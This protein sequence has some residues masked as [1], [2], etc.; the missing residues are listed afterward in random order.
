MPSKLESPGAYLF[1]DRP[2]TP[3]NE[4]VKAE[5]KTEAEAPKKKK[6]NLK[7]DEDADVF[8]KTE[9]LKPLSPEDIGAFNRAYDQELN[10]KIQKEK[11]A[12]EKLE[13]MQKKAAEAGKGEI[14]VKGPTVLQRGAFKRGE[15]VEKNKDQDDKEG[16]GSSTARDTSRKEDGDA[17]SKTLPGD[18][19]EGQQKKQKNKDKDHNKNAGDDANKQNPQHKEGKKQQNKAQGA[20]N[21]Q[22]PQNPGQ[23][24]Q[25]PRLP[26][27]NKE[28]TAKQDTQ[29]SPPGDNKEAKN[30]GNDQKNAN[31]AKKNKQQA[32]PKNPAQPKAMP[33]QP[34]MRGQEED[35]GFPPQGMPWSMMGSFPMQEHQSYP[36]GLFMMPQSSHVNPL[37]PSYMSEDMQPMG[38]YGMPPMG[39]QLNH[40]MMQ[41][42][43]YP[44]QMGQSGDGFDNGLNQNVLEEQY[45]KQMLNL[46]TQMAP[47]R[48]QPKQNRGGH[49]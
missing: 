45:I 43:F 22:N 35:M 14:P 17:T 41:M 42:P 1:V 9:G 10:A 21:Q 34:Y 27:Q 4:A 7:W 44:P 23:N 8:H 12:A 24:K 28:P 5:D 20:N 36:P 30:E 32:Q 48:M 49:Q 25:A 47:Q 18:K 29:S 19:P 46:N 26:I 33:K 40:P 6:M 3:K 11:E 31:K 39:H 13:R 15:K 38:Q 37:Y 2:P 16:D